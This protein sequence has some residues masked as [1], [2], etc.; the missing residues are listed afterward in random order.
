MTLPSAGTPASAILLGWA[1][2]SFGWDC[3]IKIAC[4]SSHK[5]RD[6]EAIL[7]LRVCEVCSSYE[8]FGHT[9]RCDSCNLWV[10]ESRSNSRRISNWSLALRSKESEG[11]RGW[12]LL[13]SLMTNCPEMQKL[14]SW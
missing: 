5:E 12:A 7:K 9:Q 2:V 10:S 6:V 1:L 8:T 11:E 3:T 14:L 4:L 13:L